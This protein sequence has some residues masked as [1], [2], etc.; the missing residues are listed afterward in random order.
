LNLTLIEY[1]RHGGTLASDATRTGTMALGILVLDGYA[2]EILNLQSCSFEED[3][4]RNLTLVA[5]FGEILILP[6]GCFCN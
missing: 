4:L 3:S 6:F 5:L 1:R 2:T